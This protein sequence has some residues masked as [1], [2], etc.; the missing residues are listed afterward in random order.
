[1]EKQILF[2]LYVGFSILAFSQEMQATSN[3]RALEESGE[4][5]GQKRPRL[6]TA[7]VIAPNIDRGDI[8]ALVIGG[9]NKTS[10]KRSWWTVSDHTCITINIDDKESFD[11][12][13]DGFEMTVSLDLPEV[14]QLYGRRGARYGQ[15]QKISYEH[16]GLGIPSSAQRSV[17]P[18]LLEFLKPGGVFSYT[19]FWVEE[20]TTEILGSYYEGLRWLIGIRDKLIPI[21]ESDSEVI[22]L[23]ALAMEKRQ[24]I[25]DKVK[26]LHQEKT[27]M[28]QDSTFQEM[29]R[30]EGMTFGVAFASGLFSEKY[31]EI[32]KEIGDGWDQY[33]KF[34]LG[35]SKLR[36]KP[37]HSVDSL[38]SRIQSK[39]PYVINVS[40]DFD[41][42][43]PQSRLIQHYQFF[44]K[45]L[46]LQDVSI[47]IAHRI[48]GGKTLYS[49]TIEGSVPV[50]QAG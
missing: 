33:S 17:V 25:R 1:M 46:G 40:T 16:V 36:H 32:Q 26:E 38:M 13:A 10:L 50:L 24:T 30:K 34:V 29:C 43:Y 5:S 41:Y 21:E 47:S 19:S 8:H 4:W 2:I 37:T 28:Q 31:T 44:T 48:Q 45:Q 7:P 39:N 15:L 22:K 6:A 9:I 20:F 3:K 27:N 23:R 14:H 11:Y 18:N 49:F 42:L 12:K 35:H